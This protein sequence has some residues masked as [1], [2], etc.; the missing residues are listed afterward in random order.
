MKFTKNSIELCGKDRKYRRCTKKQLKEHQDNVQKIYDSY[1]PIIDKV[2]AVQDEYS[3]LLNDVGDIEDE[4]NI[5]KSKELTTDDEY[6]E[7]RVLIKEKKNLR[8]EIKKVESK[9]KKLNKDAE[10]EI[11][12]IEKLIPTQLGEQASIL[13]EITP[14]EFI[15]EYTDDDELLVRYLGLFKQMADAG[16]PEKKMESVWRDIVKG[17]V[18]RKIKPI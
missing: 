11:E 12:A 8:N 16:Y 6:D 4:L 1:K 17:E 3:R 7:M 9:M 15:K 18:D 2:D 10:K 5:L 13:V 14:E